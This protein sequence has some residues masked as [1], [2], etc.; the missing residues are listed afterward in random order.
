M[1][2][3]FHYHYRKYYPGAYMAR[4]KPA[5]RKPLQGPQSPECFRILIPKP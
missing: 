1:L 2:R 5:S 4:S 3:S